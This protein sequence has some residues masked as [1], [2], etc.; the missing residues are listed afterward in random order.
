MIEMHHMIMDVLGAD[1][2]VAD[3][4]R[5]R[6][7]LVFQCIFNRTNGGHAMN[8]G[9]DT[10]DSLSIGPGITWITPFENGFNAAHHGAR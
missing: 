9:A 8:K 7:N 3:Q 6:G 5:I 1:H 4:L 2:Q 10:T